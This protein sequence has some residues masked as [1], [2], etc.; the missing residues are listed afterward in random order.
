MRRTHTA[1]TLSEPYPPKAALRRTPHPDDPSMSDIAIVEY[2]HQTLQSFSSE[3]CLPWR[4]QKTGALFLAHPGSGLDG[5]QHERLL[6]DLITAY[7]ILHSH[8]VLDEHGQISVRNP[9]EPSKLFISNTPAILV[10]SKSDL[11]QWHVTD[12]SPVA[13]CYD[14]CGQVEE[15]PQWS[16]HYARS[17]VYNIYPGV[18]SVIHSRCQSA[19]VYGLC[20][21]WKSMLQP[22]YLMAGFLRT[23]PPIFDLQTTAMNQRDSTDLEIVYLSEKEARDCESNDKPL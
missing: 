1:Q 7:H 9:R 10:S 13:K 23:S 12:G 4:N 14:G 8:E 2:D 3:L 22:S 17:S 19:I 5:G 20:N 18:Q 15:I 21:S 6:S 11:S 16:E